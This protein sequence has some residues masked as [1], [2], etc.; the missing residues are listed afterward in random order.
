M[1][2]TLYVAPAGRGFAAAA[3]PAP[4]GRRPMTPIAGVV[5]RDTFRAPVSRPGDDSRAEMW[6]ATSVDGRWQYERR[7]DGLGTLWAATF[8]PTGQ[9]R[10]GYGTSHAARR[11]TCGRLVDELRGEAF[12]VAFRGAGERE[13]ATGQR[14]L[15]VH[16]RLLGA[17]EADYRCA[18][19][20]L[21]VEATRDGKLAHVDACREC[22]VYG[23]GF[24][25]DGCEHA[26][27]VCMH[28][29]CGDPRPVECAHHL[30]RLRGCGEPAR[31]N[32]GEGCGRGETRD[33]CTDCCDGR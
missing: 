11:D 19:G 16:M 5:M 21:L 3:P 27:R 29:F 25:V 28:R 17:D 6:E 2:T 14:W 8:V 22:F 24:T 4:A 33:C 30:D 10:E 20:G 31:P 15:A 1:S 18:C 9:V 26:S 32:R 12:E 23:A 13:R 7:D